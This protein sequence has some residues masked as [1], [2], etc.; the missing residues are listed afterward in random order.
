MADSP[1]PTGLSLVEKGLQIEWSDGRTDQIPLKILRD[2]CPCATCMRTADGEGV[3]AETGGTEVS[4]ELPILDLAA[5]RPLA[6][7]ALEP[8][9][10][11]AYSINFSDGH[12]TGIYTL[13][14]LRA[15][16]L[17]SASGASR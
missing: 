1:Q 12:N 15:I 16:G 13:E 17:F 10:N 4:L 14:H 7:T 11:Y 3:T 8:M 9:G 5:A 6:I 2:A